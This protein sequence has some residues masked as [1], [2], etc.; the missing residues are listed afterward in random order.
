MWN[1]DGL[2][3][4]ECSLVA[5]HAGDHRHLSDDGSLRVEAIWDDT[6]KGA[7]PHREPKCQF[8]RADMFIAG[9]AGKDCGDIVQCPKCGLR[10]YAEPDRVNAESDRIYN[11]THPALPKCNATWRKHECEKPARHRN[12]HRATK[13][14]RFVVW[15]DGR[16][17]SVPHRD[18]EWWKRMAENEGDSVVGAGAPLPGPP[19]EPG[20]SPEAVH[21]ANEVYR[22]LYWE[23]DVVTDP[24]IDVV[25]RAL[26]SFAAAAVQAERE[27]CATVVDKWIWLRIDVR[28]KLSAIIRARGTANKEGGGK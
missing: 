1:C 5:C 16:T 25:A 22:E 26:D 9:T 21:A 7:I 19:S 10:K 6:G 2:L 14:D 12:K 20:P 23:R 27:A 4:Y 8:C 17:G 11:E 3:L 13:G 24:E 18:A 28:R 15:W